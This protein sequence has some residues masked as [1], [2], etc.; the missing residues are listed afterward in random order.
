M[1]DQ[2][3]AT[4]TSGGAG[5]TG[6]TWT[7]GFRSATTPAGGEWGKYPF[8]G[9][10]DNLRFWQGGAH[11]FEELEAIRRADMSPTGAKNPNPPDGAEGVDTT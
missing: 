7:I 4:T 8:T 10:I 3:F 11:T 6:P 2:T 9:K 1:D 5:S